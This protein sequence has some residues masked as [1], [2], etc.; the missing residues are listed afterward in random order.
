MTTC[1]QLGVEARE[2]RVA[3]L[4]VIG[5]GRVWDTVADVVE[6]RDPGTRGVCEKRPSFAVGTPATGF[7]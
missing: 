5:E 4:V 2:E 3:E 6:V 7:S 1:G